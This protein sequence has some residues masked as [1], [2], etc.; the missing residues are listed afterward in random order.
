MTY[1][2]YRTEYKTLLRRY[3]DISSLYDENEPKS[4]TLV[5]EIYERSS[6][7]T[8]W[9]KTEEKTEKITFINYS[10]IVDPRAVQFFK[11][12]GGY[13]RIITNYTKYGLIPVE[14]VSINP[15]RTYKHIRKFIFN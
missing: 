4:I 8:T 15:D 11:N 6:N 10:N 1:T 2:E 5:N 7:G 13:E 3:P 12:L 14:N 9:K